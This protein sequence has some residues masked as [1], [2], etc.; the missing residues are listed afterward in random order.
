[1]ASLFF[2]I[3]YRTHHCSF[4]EA[5]FLSRPSAYHWL[6]F[7]PL[8]SPFTSVSQTFLQGTLGISS[9]YLIMRRNAHLY[10][11]YIHLKMIW[12]NQEDPPCKFTWGPNLA[13]NLPRCEISPFPSPLAVSVSKMEKYKNLFSWW[14][15]SYSPQQREEGVLVS[16]GLSST[17]APVWSA[18]TNAPCSWQG[19]LELAH[20]SAVSGFDLFAIQ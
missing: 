16:L 3:L 5:V 17:L 4:P 6:V 1:M 8:Y 7:F 2:K 11:D 19:E 18:N 12:V 9:L 15:K 13:K 20:Y 14:Y 10:A